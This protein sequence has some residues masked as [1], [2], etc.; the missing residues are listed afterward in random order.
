MIRN[1]KL[2]P[3]ARRDDS[4]RKREGRREFIGV[5]IAKL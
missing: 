4:E 1:Y 3:S 2:M 5:Y